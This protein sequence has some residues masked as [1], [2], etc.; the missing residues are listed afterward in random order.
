M[1]HPC[2]YWHEYPL[3]CHGIAGIGSSANAN[4]LSQDLEQQ[5]RAKVYTA[6]TQTAAE[7]LDSFYTEYQV[8]S[9]IQA[10]A[11]NSE[12]RQPSAMQRR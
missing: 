3:W 6:T 4:I 11:R 9:C 1:T 8:P 7:R 5:P 2:S 12:E 10:P